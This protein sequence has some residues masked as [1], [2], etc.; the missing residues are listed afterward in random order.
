MNGVGPEQPEIGAVLIVDDDAGDRV[1]CGRALKTAFGAKQIVF[2]AACGESALD[3]VDR[4]GLACVL[5]DYAMPGLNGIEVLKRIRIKHPYL[6]VVIID[7]KGRDEIAVQSMRAGAQDYLAKSAITPQTV[8]RAVRMA[9]KY[10]NLQKRNDERVA[11]SKVFTHAL[12]HD[13]KEPVRR[14][15]G[16]MDRISDWRNLSE[17]SAR[18]LEHI[19]ISADR[20]AGLIDSMLAYTD[21]E[22]DERGERTL[23]DLNGV[24]DDASKKLETLLAERGTTIARGE[25]PQVWANCEQMVE[26]FRG[27]L[28]NA[29]EHSH[30]PVHI[31][32]NAVTA[33]DRWRLTV[34]DDGPGIAT[35]DLEAIFEPFS[36]R[37][38]GDGDGFGLGL[39][40]ARRIADLHRGRI[41]CESI[42]G[43]GATFV[44]ELPKAPAPGVEAG[45]EEGTTAIPKLA[46][47]LLVDDNDLDLEL[48]TIF[49][50]DQP[51]LRC[52][53]LVAHDGKQALVLMS[54][55]AREGRPIDLVLL[56][57]NMPVMTGFE[58]MA[59]MHKDPQ[60]KE[61]PVVMLTTSDYDK[62]RHMAEALGA[63][64]YIT[65][66]PKFRE[67][68]EIIEK[69]GH[70]RLQTEGDLQSLLRAA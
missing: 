42:L 62:D 23:C 54:E 31:E 70:F 35:E 59:E 56:D 26:L 53:R 58:L 18:A 34:R 11:A 68:K 28:R 10:C 46:R 4:T 6:P 66:P 38:G 8:F 25:L 49:L 51:K 52:E 22:L 2:E 44:I 57:I 14:I 60:L 1:Q 24:L 27:L 3:T 61:T 19:R 36:R 47:V 9:I 39:A 63:V 20:A 21:L 55:A 40:T 69:N 13:L 64:G 32:V 7:G 43:S 65:K 67:L 30:R 29:I 15:R 41:W 37:S 48:I 33:G 17:E 45:P 50:I 12:A 16:S 5:L